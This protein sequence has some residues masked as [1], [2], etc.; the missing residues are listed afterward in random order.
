V[1]VWGGGGVGGRGSGWVREV[2]QRPLEEAGT[3]PGK[4]KS[5]IEYTCSLYN[6]LGRTGVCLSFRVMVSSMP[7]HS[8][9]MLM[10]VSLG[11]EKSHLSIGCVPKQ[12]T[13]HFIVFAPTNKKHSLT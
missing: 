10:P 11:G 8:T 4:V 6:H 12:N 2:L 5:E 13:I 3:A 9:P 7:L 1:C